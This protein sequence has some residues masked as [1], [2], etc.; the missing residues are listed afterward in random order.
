MN[1]RAQ[2]PDRRVVAA[3]V[4]AMAGASSDPL[5]W[6]GTSLIGVE[7]YYYSRLVERAG[8][9]LSYPFGVEYLLAPHNGHLQL[10]GKLVYEAIFAAVGTDYLVLRVVELVGVLLCVAL[11]FE[12]LA[13]GRRDRG[14]RRG[15]PA[16]LPR[17]RLGGD[18]L[19]LRS[20][21]R[22]RLRC[23]AR[24]AA[25]A[26]ARRPGRRSGRLRAAGGLGGDDRGRPGLRRRGRRVDPLGRERLR[27]AWVFLVPAALYLTWS[28]W[29][30]RFDQGDTLVS[31]LLSD[32]AARG[33]RRGDAGG[34]GR[35]RR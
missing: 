17:R 16:A 22:L 13:P 18:D 3:L 35:A 12:L 32:P 10:T 33:F 9:H 31:N 14:A 7:L 27:R 2:R 26:R 25:G 4:L 34:D 1:G 11:V 23:R 8:E 21:H 6:T 20:A 19:A 5:G 30:T 24:G 28:L 29:A 15:R